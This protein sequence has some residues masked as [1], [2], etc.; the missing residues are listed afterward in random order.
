MR[1]MADIG[2]MQ[3]LAG[4]WVRQR[5]PIGFV[6]TM[7]FLHEGHRSLLARARR[8][9]GGRGKV[10]VSIYVNP[11]QFGPKEDFNRYPRDLKRDVALCREAEVDLVFA[12][13]DAAMY[14][15]RAKGRF[16][17]YVVEQRLSQV[18]EGR[19]RPTHFQGVTTVLAKLYNIVRP[20]V[21][22]FGAKD[23][24]QAAIVKRMASDLNLPVKT[25][26][27]PT[28]RERDGLA[29]SSR[30]RYLSPRERQQAT[31]LWRSIQH[32]RKRVRRSEIRAGRLRSEVR[33]LVHMES[34]AR[35][36]YVEFFHG[37]TLA[38]AETVCC[39]MHMALAVFVGSTRLIDNGRL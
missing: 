5:V 11:T 12:P 9:V 33:R 4:R 14:P 3:A 16:S 15:A 25:I 18:M 19:S 2:R 29:L 31:V 38:P 36:D 20:T 10:V 13:S 21:W 39:G 7:G 1:V 30:N 8:A 23:W 32:V 28:V 34:S 6:P 26:V 17:T 35:L 37:D 22:V 27:A 24:Q